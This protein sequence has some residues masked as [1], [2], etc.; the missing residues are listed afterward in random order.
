[1]PPQFPE[2]GSWETWHGLP[3]VPPGQ[4]VIGDAVLRL[5]ALE[6]EIGLGQLLILIVEASPAG[7]RRR[8]RRGPGALRTPPGGVLHRRRGERRAAPAQ[9]PG[10]PARRP[11]S[12]GRGGRRRCSPRSARSRRAGSRPPSSCCR[13]PRRRGR[14][15]SASST[16][17]PP[18]PTSTPWRRRRAADGQSP[19]PWPC[20][21][22]P[23]SGE[24]GWWRG[25]PAAPRA[26]RPS[27]W[28][29]P[30]PSTASP[31]RGAPRRSAGCW[32]AACRGWRWPTATSRG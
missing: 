32:R 11:R 27:R 17:P 12:A 20:T 28:R 1:M 18:A 10:E 26:W 14:G 6:R 7:D 15:A 4:D 9:D 30:W 22:T 5:L 29:R 8:G 25:R 16:R 19:A 21:G 13:P 3:E 2:R 23:T 24:A 31:R